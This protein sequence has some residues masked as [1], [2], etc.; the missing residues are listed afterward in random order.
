MGLVRLV[1]TGESRT[2][3]PEE[4]H[5]EYAT[6]LASSLFSPSGPLLTGCCWASRQSLRRPPSTSGSL[7]LDFSAPN[8]SHRGEDGLGVA[9]YLGRYQGFASYFLPPV[10][11]GRWHLGL[12]SGDALPLSKPLVP[13]YHALCLSACSI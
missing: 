8:P 11:R 5:P 6:S 12:P 10:L 13:T 4:I 1:E 9:S 7:H 3:R 2:P